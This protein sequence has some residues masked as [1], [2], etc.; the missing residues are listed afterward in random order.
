ME[1]F[2]EISQYTPVFT[3]ANVEAMLNGDP[4]DGWDNV[5]YIDKVFG[6]GINPGNTM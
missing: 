5:N 1:V 3:K 6:T 4:T 2:R